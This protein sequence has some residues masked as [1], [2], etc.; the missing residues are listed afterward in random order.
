MHELLQEHLNEFGLF[1]Y[2]IISQVTNDIS[3]NPPPVLTNNVAN[4]MVWQ[5]KVQI[6]PKDMIFLR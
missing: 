5:N 3:Y 2:C 4:N 6:F 1:I